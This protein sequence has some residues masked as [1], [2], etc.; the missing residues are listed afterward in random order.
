MTAMNT[1]MR[2]HLDSA[3]KIGARATD[4]LPLA[5]LISSNGVDLEIVLPQD[6]LAAVAPVMALADR[7]A[8]LA[9]QARQRAS[10][11]RS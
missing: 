9:D 3:S 5:L 6:Q 2:L 7:T 8:A 4:G 10:E 11:G 1:R